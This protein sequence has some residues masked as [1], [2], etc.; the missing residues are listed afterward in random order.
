[1]RKTT[2]FILMVLFL[3]FATGCGGPVSVVKKYIK[4]VDEFDSTK[5]MSYCTGPMLKWL[6]FLEGE[7]INTGP[8]QSRVKDHLAEI[9]KDKEY[10]IKIKEKSGNRASVVVSEKNQGGGCTYRLVKVNGS[11]KIE[12]IETPMM[13]SISEAVDS[14]SE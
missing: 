9:Y 5:A 7:Q 4:A 13:G 1:M 10:V 8:A 12:D 3:L 6:M 14:L 2:T 11:W